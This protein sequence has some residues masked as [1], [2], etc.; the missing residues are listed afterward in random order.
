VN[1][2]RIRASKARRRW[3]VNGS[4]VNGTPTEEM[5]CGS[6]SHTAKPRVTKGGTRYSDR[7]SYPVEV[8]YVS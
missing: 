7:K 1:N 6:V 5:L 8:R 4:K 2:K 3:L